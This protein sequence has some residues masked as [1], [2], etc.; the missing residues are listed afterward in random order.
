MEEI[1]STINFSTLI[2][3]EPLKLSLGVLIPGLI[4]AAWP[5]IK[6]LAGIYYAEKATVTEKRA[7]AFT[8]TSE[9]YKK[10]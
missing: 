4:K 2:S 5:I 8:C 7:K 9:L 6:R 3:T 1:N 10:I